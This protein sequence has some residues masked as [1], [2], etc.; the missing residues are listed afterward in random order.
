VG[1]DR[2]RAGHGA[3]YRARH[4]RGRAGRLAYAV[5]RGTAGVG[6]PGRATDA[7]YRTGSGQG[8]VGQVGR[9]RRSV[10]R[11]RGKARRAVPGWVRWPTRGDGQGVAGAGHGAAEVEPRWPVRVVRGE[12]GA[13]AQLGWEGGE[14]GEEQKNGL[15]R[16]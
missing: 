5:R 3:R 12:R 10:G 1:H 8:R 9:P 16:A 4:G 13:G 7:R 14:S 15:A 6:G 11:G 2:G